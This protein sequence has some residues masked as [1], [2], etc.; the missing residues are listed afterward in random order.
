MY[1]NF[2][3]H[4]IYIWK[5][6]RFCVKNDR[7]RPVVSGTVRPSP[8]LQQTTFLSQCTTIRYKIRS[9]VSANCVFK[10]SFPFSRNKILYWS[11]FLLWFVALI[12]YR[13]GRVWT[14]NCGTF[15]ELSESVT[16]VCTCRSSGCVSVMVIGV[17]R[18]EQWLCVSDG[19]THSPEIW[20]QYSPFISAPITTLCYSTALLNEN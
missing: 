18:Q 9:H 19:D 14:A 20:T 12:S 6:D 3:I 2:Y 13:S 1:I 17:Y 8:A 15:L 5:D 4:Y 16:A 11:V 7:H 10:L